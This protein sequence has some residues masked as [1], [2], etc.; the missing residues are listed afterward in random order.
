MYPS[1]TVFLVRG[2]FVCFCCDSVTSDAGG[3]ADVD[4]DVGWVEE[5]C[6]EWEVLG[7]LAM[8]VSLDSRFSML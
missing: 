4:V 6:D 7:G 1:L 5:V 3:G 2:A 8:S